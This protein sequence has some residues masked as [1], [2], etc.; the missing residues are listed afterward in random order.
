MVDITKLLGIAVQPIVSYAIN[1]GEQNVS[2]R[3]HR[4]FLGRT[5]Y[6]HHRDY[7]SLLGEGRNQFETD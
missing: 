3:I 1:T 7:R 6:S 5:N 4:A 2:E